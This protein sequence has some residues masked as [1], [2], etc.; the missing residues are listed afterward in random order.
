M[1]ATIRSLTGRQPRHYFG[2]TQNPDNPAVRGLKEEVLRVYRSRVANP[3]WITSIQKHGYKGGLELTA[4]VDYL[5]GYD[6][7]AHVVDDWVYEDLAGRYALD[8]AMQQFFAE[9]NPWA[10]NAIT[11]RLLEAAQRQLW[12]Q[13]KPETLAALQALHLQSEALLE[14]RGEGAQA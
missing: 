13:P 4:T 12:E 10:L 1:I 2:D 9:S 6:A 8:P 3:K 7:T 14:A 11:E 5:F